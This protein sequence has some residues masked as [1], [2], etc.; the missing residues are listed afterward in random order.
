[1]SKSLVIVESP[2]KARTLGK[3]LGKDYRIEATKGHIR[4]LPEKKIGVDVKKGFKP[5]YQVMP[6]REKI[7]D[8]LKKVA[9]KAESIYLAPDPD[10]EGEAIAWHVAELL[11]ITDKAYRATFNEVTKRAVQHAVQN[12]GRLNHSLIDAQQARRILDRLVG[13]KISPLLG[14]HFRWGLSA[15]RVQSVA[16]RLIVEREREVRAFVPVE[17]WTIEA[18]A[19][20]SQ[21]PPFELKLASIRGKKAEIKT[22]DQAQRIVEAVTGKPFLVRSLEK[23]D[24]RRNPPPPFIT[25]TLQQ[26]ASR[27]L[28]MTSSRTMSIAQHLYEGVELGTEGSIGLITYMRTDSVH[29]SREAVESARRFIQQTYGSEY[30]PSAAPQYKSSKAAQEAHEAIR[31]TDL[32]WTPERA[33]AHL[34]KDELALYRLIWNRFLASQMASAIIDQTRVEASPDDGI[35]VFSATGQVLRFRGFLALYEEGKDDEEENG[36]TARKGKEKDEEESRLPPMTVGEELDIKEVTPSQHFTKPPARFTEATLVRELERL[37]IGRPST[38]A[39]IIS[40]IQKEY[41]KKLKGRFAPTETGEVITDALVKSFPDIMDVNFTAHMETELDEIEQGK[42]DWVAVLE[43]F[44][45]KFSK[46]LKDADKII[47]DLKGETIPTEHKCPVCG[48]TM[49]LRVGKNGRF[50]SCSR[51][52][53]CK[54]TLDVVMTEDGGFR[55]VPKTQLAEEV[56]CERCSKPMVLKSGRRG[57]FL[58]CSGYPE[59]KNTMNVMVCE[60]GLM[61]P[62]K[63]IGKQSVAVRA[64][65]GAGEPGEKPEKRAPTAVATGYKCDECG[66]PMVAR[67]GRYGPFLACTGYPECKAIRKITRD[68][69]VTLPPAPPKKKPV[70]TDIPC[71]ECGKPMVIRTSRRGPFLGC[72]AFPKCKAT[73]PLPDDLKEKTPG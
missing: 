59:C 12:P 46:R 5:E 48:S 69:N 41:V 70:E 35:H 2:A 67:R 65:E 31:P 58:S 42:M 45:D 47:G 36:D 62:A 56:T 1:M 50:L 11:G 14:R 54:T 61:R 25:S 73:Q 57:P 19:R 17:Y 24:V 13:Y 18:Q 60:D 30:A 63:P 51:Y 26:E 53:D 7:V 49:N 10:R 8:H 44:W 28:R 37:G 33:A 71:P 64:E 43:E 23:R 29:L 9:E 52:P 32:S 66:R 34:G 20:A 55:P 38:Y 4:D 3:Y 39:S 68:M 16:V 27:K 22:G 40:T 21:P 6:R 72:S 15:G